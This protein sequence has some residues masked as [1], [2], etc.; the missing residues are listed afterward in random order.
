[1][2]FQE[3]IQKIQKE[4][5][6]KKL[7]IS[8][9][10]S[11]TYYEFK[12]FANEENFCEDYG[13]ALKFL[14]DFYNGCIPNGM[15]LIEGRLQQMEEE[16]ATLQQQLIKEEKKPARKSLDGTELGGNRK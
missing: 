10:P 3:H 16:I 13:M 6:K 8:R 5:S 4:I 2:E 11:N 12:E 1:M 7:I 14:M 15:E 9:V